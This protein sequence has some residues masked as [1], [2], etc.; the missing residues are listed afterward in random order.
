MQ[1][2]HVIQSHGNAHIRNI[3]KGEVRRRKS[4]LFKLG[5]GQV[6]GR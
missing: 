3:C 6:H 5:G 1:K 2:S 4:K